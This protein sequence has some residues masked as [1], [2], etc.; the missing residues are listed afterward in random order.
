MHDELTGLPGRPALL[1]A[2][3]TEL[4]Q[5]QVDPEHQFAVLLLNL[6][7]FKL[8]NDSVGPEYA[9]QLLV[10]FVERV[11]RCLRPD[12]IVARLGGGELA[13]L[14]HKLQSPLHAASVCQSIQRE[15]MAAFRL[16]SREVITTVSIGVVCNDHPARE[17]EDM[18][19]DA[20]GAQHEGSRRGPGHYT[21]YERRMHDA[22]VETF[23]LEMDLRRA[24]ARREFC[25]HYQPIV[26]LETGSLQGFEALLRWNHPEQGLVPPGRF[27][28]LAEETGLIV[29]MERWVLREGCRT[30]RTWR[31]LLPP[32]HPLSLHLN[33]SSKH[34]SRPDLAPELKRTLVEFDLD[35]QWIRM[36]ITETA[37]AENPE[38]AID[39]LHEL[40]ALGCLLSVD[41]FGTG[42]SSL[43][44]LQRYPID[45]LKIDRAFIKSIDENSTSEEIVRLILVL[46]DHFG[47]EAI[48]EGIETEE[49]LRVLREIGCTVGQGFLFSRPVDADRAQEFVRQSAR[50]VG[51]TPPR[52]S[53]A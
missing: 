38:V 14:L 1:R 28:P 40:R 52:R 25:L 46:A 36:E 41:D 22:A 2:I 39:V 7:R 5:A 29:P 33:I 17:A 13:I 34:L 32:T 42:Y 15:G 37:I 8:I 18:L 35:P 30:I 51:L 27:V 10:A 16:G 45:L 12:D 44:C 47:L 9:D 50:G 26:D 21:I 3:E 23:Q 48:A 20:G 4:E 11:R 49:Q 6:D 24:L 43:A 53:A 31:N 19:R